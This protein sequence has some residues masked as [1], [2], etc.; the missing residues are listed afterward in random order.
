VYDTREWRAPPAG[1]YD[2]NNDPDF[3]AQ[4]GEKANL[5]GLSITEYMS[6]LDE[7]EPE[8]PKIA[9]KY[10][11]GA[12]LLEHESMI[13]DLPTK[14]RRLHNW[15]MKACAED[16]NWIYAR[17]KQEH[18]GHGDGFVLI[19]FPELF[20]FYQG[21]ALDKTLVSSYCL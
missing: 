19:E 13:K 17:F 21:N 9:Y 6:R 1:Q 2:P 7:F 20:M 11:H 5:F 15:Y 16:K 3:I 18:Y 10:R 4:Y 12:P 14:M 8:G